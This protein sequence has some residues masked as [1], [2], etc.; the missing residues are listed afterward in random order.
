M[1]TSLLKEQRCECG[2]LL[3]KGIFFDGTLE[4]KCKKCGAINKIG[5]I[6][7]VDDSNH[8]LLVI[9]EKGNIVNASSSACKILGYYKEELIGMHF[10]KINPTMPKEINDKFFGP[11]SILNEDNHFQIETTHQTKDGK[12]IPVF[13]FIKLYQ[14]VNKERFLFVS[15]ELK[16]I[17]KN[18][19]NNES[20]F[21]DNTCDLY[22]DI[23]KN[24]II[25]RVSS[26]IEKLLGFSQEQILGK[27]YFDLIPEEYK[28]ESKKIYEHFFAIEQPYRVARD[29]KKDAGG[30]VIYD[31]IYVTPNYND[32]G[33]FIGCRVLVWITKNS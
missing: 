4:I 18:I 23:D 19:N 17:E 12:K 24:G 32:R 6:K 5:N 9:N 16:N 26:N 10:T 7:L 3:L 2:K 21:I 27:N 14:Q 8:Y 22:F 33:K 13:V 1:D 31:E 25:E 15:A 29:I 11:E 28:T 20:M 30:K